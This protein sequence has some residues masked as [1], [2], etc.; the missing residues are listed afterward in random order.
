M[1]PAAQELREQV[2]RT[3]DVPAE[4][5]ALDDD[6]TDHGLTSL[7]LVSLIEDWNSRGIEVDVADF[8][9]DPRLSAVVARLP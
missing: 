4:G 5:I 8:L 7:G 6:L 1:S 2:A 9:A 3:L